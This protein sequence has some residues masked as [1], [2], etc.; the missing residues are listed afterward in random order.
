MLLLLHP[1]KGTVVES[2]DFAFALLWFYITLAVPVPVDF[3]VVLAVI[4]AFARVRWLFRGAAGFLLST[5]SLRN[6]VVVVVVV[7]AGPRVSRYLLIP[8]ENVVV[9][10]CCWLLL[11]GCLLI[12]GRIRGETS[13]PTS[14]KIIPGDF[15]KPYLKKKR[16]L[17]ILALAK[18]IGF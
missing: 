10:G 6:V 9:V 16:F 3:D 1:P 13:H 11:F 8:C 14:C 17:G 2:S 5:H 15:Q 4:V 7:V 12:P 18:N